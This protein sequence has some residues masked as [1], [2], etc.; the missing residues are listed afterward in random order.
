MR[1][2]F[3]ICDRGEQSQSS[4]LSPYHYIVEDKTV[5]D[6]IQLSILTFHCI[7]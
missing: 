7:N 6:S 5:N 2:N 3:K 1:E 4:T